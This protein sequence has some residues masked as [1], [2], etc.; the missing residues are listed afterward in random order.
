MPIIY[1]EKNIAGK[2]G[3][4]PCSPANTKGFCQSTLCAE[5]S[6]DGNIIYR[7]GPMVFYNSNLV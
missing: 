1:R 5:L 2:F 6:R 4:C 3:M 7:E